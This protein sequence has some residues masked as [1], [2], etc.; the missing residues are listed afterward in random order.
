M[1]V[2]GHSCLSVGVAAARRGIPLHRRSH[3]LEVD[4]VDVCADDHPRRS[5]GLAA[6]SAQDLLQVE[7]A[8]LAS[9]TIKIAS[10]IQHCSVETFSNLRNA[11]FLFVAAPHS[12][13]AQEVH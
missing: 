13:S 8:G 10:D 4:V 11:D 9:S 12:K 3:E 6:Q 5:C 7:E 2:N 1:S